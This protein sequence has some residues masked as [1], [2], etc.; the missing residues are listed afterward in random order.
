[1]SAIRTLLEAADNHDLDFGAVLRVL[2]A[3]GAGEA[4][5]AACGGPT[6]TQLGAP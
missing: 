5:C 6:S 3:T 2:V 4:R 1:M